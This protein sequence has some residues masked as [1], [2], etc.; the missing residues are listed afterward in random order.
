MSLEACI[1]VPQASEASGLH[2][3]GL[4]LKKESILL[5]TKDDL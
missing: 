4:K 1:Q 2:L 5:A 3:L